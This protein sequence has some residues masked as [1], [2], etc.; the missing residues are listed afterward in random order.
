MNS[1]MIR[2]LGKD[3]N[4]LLNLSMMQSSVTKE[5]K[6]KEYLAVV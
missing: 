6:G 4:V 1:V 5:T 2:R 3:N